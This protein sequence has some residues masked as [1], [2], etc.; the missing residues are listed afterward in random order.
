MK[1]KPRVLFFARKEAAVHCR[2]QVTVAMAM[3]PQVDSHCDPM[4][5][6][7]VLHIWPAGTPFLSLAKLAL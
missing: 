6:T 2:W 3:L 4:V 7:R 1:I 5:R